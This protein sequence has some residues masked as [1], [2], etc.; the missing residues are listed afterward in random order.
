MDN[1]IRKLSNKILTISITNIKNGN[2]DHT[3]NKANQRN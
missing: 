2:M 3:N 1:N